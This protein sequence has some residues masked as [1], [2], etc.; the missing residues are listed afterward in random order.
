MGIE[1]SADKPILYGCGDFIND[2]EGIGGHDAFRPD[3]T[4]AYFIDIDDRNHR[5]TQLLMVPFRIR[6]FRLNWV[7]HADATWLAGTMNRECL[8][9]GHHVRLNGDRAL[10]LTW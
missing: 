1:V 9:F 4:L 8:R 6:K 5:S 3:L 10:T 2:Y 7:E